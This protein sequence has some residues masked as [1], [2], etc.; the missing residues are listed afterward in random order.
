ML[1]GSYPLC[2]S[3]YMDI[4]YTPDMEKPTIETDDAAEAR[5]LVAAISDETNSLRRRLRLRHLKKEVEA[6]PEVFR[7]AYPIGESRLRRVSS[8]LMRL[9]PS[10]MPAHYSP[11]LH[12]PAEAARE[13]SATIAHTLGEQMAD[14]LAREDSLD[15]SF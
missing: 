12:E 15:S 2:N 14:F 5:I 6:S 3:T 1:A 13:R 11:G 10:D 8:H 7:L 4:R 9:A